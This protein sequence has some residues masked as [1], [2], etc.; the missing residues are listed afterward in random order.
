M[1]QILK[2]LSVTPGA[3]EPPKAAKEHAT[4]CHHNP[5]YIITFELDWLLSCEYMVS[6][7]EI[8]V[9]LYGN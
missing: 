3:H 5:N 2:H 7:N 6:N 4:E 9:S 1:N 8:A